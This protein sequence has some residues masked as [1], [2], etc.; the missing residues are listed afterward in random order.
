[1]NDLENKLGVKEEELK[2]NEIELVARNER[3]KGFQAELRLLK[4]ELALLY[5]E[6]KSLYDQLNEAKDEAGVTAANMVSEYQSST[7]MAAL[8]QTIW[9]EAFKEV[10]ESFAYTT[11]TQLPDW[12]L[13][14]LGDHLVTQIAEW[15]VEFQ[16][17]HPPAEDPPVVPASPADDI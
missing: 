10:A 5:A 12:D 9:D 16:A 3:Y 1:M 17:S 6:N 11:A 15:R 8:R 7:E 14:Y 13:A 2:N 4:G